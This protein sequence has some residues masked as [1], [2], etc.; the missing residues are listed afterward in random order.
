MHLDLRISHA[1]RR[2]RPQI[3]CQLGDVLNFKYPGLFGAVIDLLKPLM[4][5][6]D[7]VWPRHTRS[8]LCIDTRPQKRWFGRIIMHH[9]LCLVCYAVR[10]GAANLG[11]G[12]ATAVPR[13]GAWCSA[14]SGPESASAC[15]WVVIRDGGSRS[16]ARISAKLAQS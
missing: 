6:C 4:D 7:W 2:A 8:L 11:D 3:T 10:F 12:A 16:L 9:K 13:C 5:A 15:I 14:H 1:L